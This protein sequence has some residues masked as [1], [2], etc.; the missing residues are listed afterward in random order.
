MERAPS[1]F[2][3]LDPLRLVRIVVEA[4][5]P[6]DDD[7]EM[8][9]SD[10]VVNEVDCIPEEREDVEVSDNSWPKT[11][12][13]VCDL[14]FVGVDGRGY[15]RFKSEALGAK[16]EVCGL[17]Y[18]KKCGLDPLSTRQ[19]P[20]P[21]EG[22]DNAAARRPHR[23]GADLDR[24]GMGLWTGQLLFLMEGKSETSAAADASQRCPSGR[25]EVL[26]G[27]GHSRLP[28]HRERLERAELQ[29]PRHRFPA[30]GASAHT[31]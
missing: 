23:A 31:R 1:D 8:R 9:P 26:R 20:H 12:K 22:G 5:H 29:L 24:A 3:P 14:R 18:T 21:N 7:A 17:A 10:W 13:R 30:A 28:P 2:Q 6:P 11:L 19:L 27:S 4:P 16:V 15:V 25:H